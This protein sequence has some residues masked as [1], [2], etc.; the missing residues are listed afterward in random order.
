MRQYYSP[1]GADGCC[2]T[3]KKLLTC[4]QLVFK[5]NLWDFR[6]SGLSASV[7]LSCFYHITVDVFWEFRDKTGLYLR[8]HAGCSETVV[9][10]CGL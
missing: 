3:S 10:L 7:G 1:D 5:S 6:R 9:L 8:V 2:I 4:L